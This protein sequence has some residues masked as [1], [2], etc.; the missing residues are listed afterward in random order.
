M[1]IATGDSTS[2][3]YS[4]AEEKPPSKKRIMVRMGILGVILYGMW[5]AAKSDT[6]PPSPAPSGRG[7]YQK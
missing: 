7:T 6:P 4:D 2:S 5:E 3:N 1:F